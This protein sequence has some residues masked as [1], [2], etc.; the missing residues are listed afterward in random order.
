[1]LRTAAR[2]TAY[3][4]IT[5]TAAVKVYTNTE[6]GKGIKRQFQFW[7]QVTPIIAEY[8]FYASSA[9]PFV[10]YYQHGSEEERK[11]T[12]KRLHEKNAPKLLQILNDLKGLYIKLGQVLSV[13]T[14]PLPQIY[15]KY[16]RTLQSDV[17]GHEDYDTVIKG[18]IEEELGKANITGNID[19]VFDTIEKIP[20][21]AA[22]IGQCHRAKLKNDGLASKKQKQDDN[23]DFD[24]VIKVQYPQ[25]S[26][27]VPADIKCIGQFLQFCVWTEIIDESSAQLSYEEFSRQF[28]SELDYLSEAEN[29]QTIYN[30][31]LD[32]NAPYQKRSIVVP[33]LF[34]HLSTNK[35]ITMEYIPGPKIEDEAR[36]QLQLLGVRTDRSIK[37]IIKE[38]LND[39]NLIEKGEDMDTNTSTGGAAQKQDG[40][41][42][43]AT[44][45]HSLNRQQN[46]GHWKMTSMNIVRKLVGVDVI[47]VLLRTL[48]KMRLLA[49]VATASFIKTLPASMLPLSWDSWAKE[50]QLAAEQVTKLGLTKD[51]IDA[52]FDVHGHQIFS[53]GC[54]N[55][56]CHPG[57]IL[58][59]D[60][61]NSS[62]RKL[63]LIDFGQ[64]KRLNPEE[65]LS[66][67]KLI[68]SVANNES[69][70]TIANNFR[71]MGIKTREDSTE[72]LS[73][74]SKLLFGRF[75]NEHMSHSWHMELH[76]MDKVLYF[77]KELSMVY[78]TS[79]LLRGLAVSLQM[80]CSVGQQWKS[81]AQAVVDRHQH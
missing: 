47:L 30:S 17:P 48:T 61:K 62:P 75:E 2:R 35:I 56:D 68:L 60:D 3:G 29:L 78:R 20:C 10:K 40:D 81:H 52:L 19:D 8:C 25:A 59:V 53:L 4:A 27:Q 12:L 80:N 63:G 57:N 6:D 46:I 32:P 44:K 71:Q 39:A 24:V 23:D 70:E 77:P 42:R 49:Q 45:R 50:H 76:K 26:W 72:F 31:S 69:D 28:L 74:F 43:R 21:G 66:I 58:V 14:L 36:K 34:K 15:K 38:S 67:A 18:I 37:E 54:F 73:K 11:R 13:T 5:G 7:S 65:Q 16:L 41:S 64:C 33:K 55:A 22:S 1:M 51:W 9:S 79:L